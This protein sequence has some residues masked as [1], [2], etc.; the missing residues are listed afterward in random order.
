MGSQ[1][2]PRKM[3]SLIS[4]LVLATTS[5]AYLFKANLHLEEEGTYYNQTEVYDSATGDVITIVPAHERQGLH[6]EEL[7]KIENEGL[8]ISIWKLKNANVCYIEELD[9]NYHPVKFVLKVASMEADNVTLSSSMLDTLYILNKDSGTW[10]G[11]EDILTENMKNMCDGFKI[12]EVKEEAITKEEFEE[13]MNAGIAR[14]KRRAQAMMASC[15][16]SDGS[17]NHD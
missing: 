1:Q 17:C 12:R 2:Q 16:N 3:R 13:L 6:L 11:D 9:D 7:K 5:K 10:D 8:K 4:L 15:Y 14:K